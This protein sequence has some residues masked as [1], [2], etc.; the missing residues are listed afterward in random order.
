MLGNF[1]IGKHNLAVANGAS[2][3]LITWQ[4]SILFFFW[5]TNYCTLSLSVYRFMGLAE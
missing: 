3:Y 2:V 5:Q 1:S 4:Y